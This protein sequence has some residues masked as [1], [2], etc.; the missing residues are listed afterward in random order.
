M[1]KS[2]L[3]HDTNKLEFHH[4][5]PSVWNTLLNSYD[6]SKSL[7]ASELRFY[8]DITILMNNWYFSNDVPHKIG[9]TKKRIK[10]EKTFIKNL[11]VMASPV[12]MYGA[13]KYASLNYTKGMLYSRVLNSFRRHQLKLVLGQKN[14]EYFEG[15][16][17]VN[18]KNKPKQFSG[19]PH[20][21]HMACNYIFALTYNTLAF[22]GG[23]FDDRP[24][25]IVS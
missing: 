20:L 13:E 9:V 15:V 14:D 5:M 16:D 22:D 3:R 12:L 21:A 10:S 4:I 1:Q 24:K 6:L 23:I 19:L 18:L 8:C 11:I 25:S 7:T 2:A 17:P